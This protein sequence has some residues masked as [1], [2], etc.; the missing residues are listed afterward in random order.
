LESFLCPDKGISRRFGSKLGLVYSFISEVPPDS[1]EAG[2][3]GSCKS[4]YDQSILIQDSDFDIP[5]R[6]GLQIVIN[7]SSIRRIASRALVIR[8]TLAA[9]YVAEAVCGP[10]RKEMDTGF[11]NFWRK[12]LERCDIIHNPETASIGSYNQVVKMILDNHPVNWRMRKIGLKR[13]PTSTVVKGYVNRIFCPQIK[14]AFLHRVFTDA[15]SIA[16]HTLGDIGAD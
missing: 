6:S 16:E 13:N 9:S 3:F 12:L 2:F 14:Q 1:V 15:M 5:F 11:E 8:I 7:G 10:G 4:S